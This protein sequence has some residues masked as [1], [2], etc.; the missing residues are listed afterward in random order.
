MQTL[1]SLAGNYMYIYENVGRVRKCT[2]TCMRIWA[3]SGNV[4]VHVHVYGIVIIYILLKLASTFLTKLRINAYM[5]VTKKH[6]F[7]AL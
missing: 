3:G 7:T 4:H 1:L 2:C 6:V 5:N